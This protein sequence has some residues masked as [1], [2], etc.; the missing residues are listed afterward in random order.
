MASELRNTLLHLFPRKPPG[1]Q[2]KLSTRRRRDRVGRRQL[3]HRSLPVP[4]GSLDTLPTGPVRFDPS[5]KRAGELMT[6]DS[7]CRIPP[8]GFGRSET[9]V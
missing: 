8:S 3:H 2:R 7:P 5:L 9:D 6:L 1:H 4:F